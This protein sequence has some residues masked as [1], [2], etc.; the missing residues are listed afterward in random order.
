[1]LDHKET[2]TFTRIFA[3]PKNNDC[4]LS[5]CNSL[6]EPTSPFVS[7]KLDMKAPNGM[8]RRDNSVIY[9]LQGENENHCPV[10]IS[11]TLGMGA[12]MIPP[13]R[14]SFLRMVLGN[15]VVEC[16]KDTPLH[17]YSLMLMAEHHKQNDSFHDISLLKV[18]EREEHHRTFIEEQKFHVYGLEKFTF[19][20]P[21]SPQEQ[22]LCFFKDFR[23][24]LLLKHPQLPPALKKAILLADKY[25]PIA[26]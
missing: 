15:T 18:E 22:W 6:L 5:L 8:F 17:L 21:L 10:E 7:I 3:D 20:N 11:L 2:S 4:L 14:E 23:N 12:M 16:E 25:N 26:P 13:W 9:V 24:P 1:M 19:Q